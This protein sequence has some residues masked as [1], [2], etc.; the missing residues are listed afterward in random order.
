M[1]PPAK[2]IRSGA[3]AQEVLT[4]T[5]ARPPRGSRCRSRGRL[6][7]EL[8]QAVD[9]SLPGELGLNP[10][11]PGRAHGPAPGGVGQSPAT[12]AATGPG[13]R[14]STTVPVSP[15]TTVSGAPPER[16]ATTGSP[17]AA[18]S[19]NTT[20]RASRSSPSQRVRHGMANTSPAA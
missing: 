14:P 2:L 19:R 5:P 20:P 13:R 1:P 10:A 12:A 11:P 4:S 15:S 9:D 3:L 6:G 18:A 17:V 16:P 8:L 7:Q